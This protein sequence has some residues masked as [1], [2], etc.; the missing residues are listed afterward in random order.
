MVANEQKKQAMSKAMMQLIKRATTHM[1]AGT[2]KIAK[3]VT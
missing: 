3:K 2:I 1:A